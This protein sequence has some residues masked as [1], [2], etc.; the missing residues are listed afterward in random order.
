MKGVL[1]EWDKIY[2]HLCPGFVTLKSSKDA[3]RKYLSEEVV[4]NPFL[5]YNFETSRDS[6]TQT[7]QRKLAHENWSMKTN[8][9]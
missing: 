9:I 1:S 4:F 2:L 7:H 8:L 6:V 5:I 3:L